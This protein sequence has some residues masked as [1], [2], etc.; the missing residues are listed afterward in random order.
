MPRT[1]E[2]QFAVVLEQREVEVGQ[3][4][5]IMVAAPNVSQGPRGRGE[6]PHL[7][8]T[9]RS[10]LLAC[11]LAAAAM[12]LVAMLPRL[13]EMHSRREGSQVAFRNTHLDGVLLLAVRV[14]DGLERMKSRLL[15]AGS[16]THPSVSAKGD[17]PHETEADKR[18]VRGMGEVEVTHWPRPPTPT[19]PTVLP[20]PAPFSTSGV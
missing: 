3:G 20:G 15:Q 8:T 17:T 18:Q 11:S 5:I 6:P 19:M 9:S 13:S 12:S 4:L 14:R 7:V 16:K 2:D 10:N 1:N